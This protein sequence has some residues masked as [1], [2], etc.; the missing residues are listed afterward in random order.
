[1]HVPEE[2]DRAQ[3]AARGLVIQIATAITFGGLLIAAS[4]GGM[5]AWSRGRYAP[6]LFLLAAVLTLAASAAGL[7]NGWPALLANLPTTAPLQLQLLGVLAVAGIG[8]TL[9]AAMVG[10]AIGALP[11]RLAKL[12]RVADQDAVMLGIAAGLFGAAVGAAAS[13]IRTPIWARPPAV[14]ALGSLVPFLDVAIDPISSFLTAMAVLLTAVIAFDRVTC[15]W[16]RRRAAAIA[17]LAIVGF[18][19]G[20]VPAGSHTAG[21]AVAGVLMSTALI[22]AYVTLLRFDPTLVPLALGTMAA[23]R[24]LGLVVHGAFPGA[25]AGGVLAAVVVSALAWWWFRLL[26]RMV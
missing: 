15:G 26:R 3:R 14:D 6:R 16:T 22:G 4:I 25:A 7:L 23:V 8:L 5:M 21:W 20:G 17:G 9:L 18:L 13:A 19:T 2:W 11:H 10:L 24:A 1:V 12:G